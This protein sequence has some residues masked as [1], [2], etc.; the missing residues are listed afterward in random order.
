MLVDSIDTLEFRVE[1][2][3]APILLGVVG[4]EV[5]ELLWNDFWLGND[6]QAVVVEW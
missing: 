2:C 5:V 6:W 1:V 3:V 4:F